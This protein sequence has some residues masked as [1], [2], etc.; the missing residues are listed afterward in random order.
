[1]TKKRKDTPLSDGKKIFT[2]NL[3]FYTNTV[4]LS[5]IY[6][7]ISGKS[8]KLVGVVQRGKHLLQ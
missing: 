3:A 8:S 1:M 5:K 6:L 2:Y 7:H 4:L